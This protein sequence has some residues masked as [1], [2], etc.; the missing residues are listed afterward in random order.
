MI[1]FF[2][3]VYLFVFSLISYLLKSKDALCLLANVTDQSLLCCFGA[4]A[5]LNSY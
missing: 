2:F 3:V 1:G 5:I 4:T